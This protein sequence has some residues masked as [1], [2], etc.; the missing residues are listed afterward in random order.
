M[1]YLWIFGNAICANV[2]NLRY[3]GLYFAFGIFA[4]ITH[5]LFSDMP[6]VGASGAI[7]GMIGF[8]FILYPYNPIECWWFF[9]LRMGTF[10]VAGI[11]LIGLWFLSDIIGAV[12]GW[13]II[14]YWAHLGGF[15]I[16]VLCAFLMLK[17]KV[18][19]LSEDDNETMV[20]Y[21]NVKYSGKKMEKS[22]RI[23][24]SM[25]AS[26]P[27]MHI[28]PVIRAGAA[29]PEKRESLKFL[30]FIK[31]K[32][33]KVNTEKEPIPEKTGGE[34]MSGIGEKSYHCHANGM[35]TGPFTAAQIGEAIASGS[36]TVDD[37]VYAPEENDWVLM[38]D[39]FEF[40]S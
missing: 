11:W 18:L 34:E 38:R 39:Y 10:E 13:G 14:A 27:Y 3:L 23:R 6:A 8:Y 25:P 21:W 15:L 22:E 40:E 26:N 12:L 30:E 20:D 9:M 1:L 29:L 32:Q 35:Q 7:N 4:S 5:L 19:V 28:S 31:S 36:L 33:E 16:G 17:Y 2:G 37:W 24:T